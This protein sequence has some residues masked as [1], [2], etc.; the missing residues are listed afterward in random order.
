LIDPT[1]PDFDNK[2]GSS[3]RPTFNYELADGEFIPYVT[4]I[5]PFYN[6]GDIFLETAAS[7]FH[8]SFQQFEWI[9]IND[10]TDRPDSI[11]ILDQFRNKDERL[12]IVDHNN[13]KGLSAARNTGFKLAKAKYV[14]QIDSDDLLEETALEKWLWFLE[15][16]PEYSFCKG[17][18]IGF[19][20]EKYLWDYG[21][22]DG[23][24]F[25]AKNFTDA[26]C[27]VKKNVHTQVG[28]YDDKLKEGLEDWDFWIKCANSGF[29]GDNIPEYLNWY[30]RRKD[31]SDK[32][33]NLDSFSNNAN[34]I[35]LLKERYPELWKGKFPSI[36]D[37]ESSHE[38]KTINF[39]NY[40]N[41]LKKEK[42]RVLIL[43]SS[44][45]NNFEYDIS[46][47]F[48]KQ[49]TKENCELSVITFN[50]SNNTNL[51]KTCD[52][53]P[54]VFILPNFLRL[55]DYP[56]F[57]IYFLISRQ[58]DLILFFNYSTILSLIP[59][60][61]RLSSNIKLISLLYDKDI[62]Q[63]S[64]LNLINE[65]KQFIDLKLLL[66]LNSE[67]LK[68]HN[69]ISNNII[70]CK[71]MIDTE[72]WNPNEKLRSETR[73]GL[74]I[75]ED[76]RV[77]ICYF[78]DCTHKIRPR[79]LF[80][81]ILELAKKNLKFNIIIA[82]KGIN[83]DWINLL[84][85]KNNI[86]NYCR[87]V[88]IINDKILNRLFAASDLFFLP[89]EEVSNTLVI[90]RAM[91]FKLCIVGTSNNI[92]KGIID[93]K[94]G[95]VIEYSNE[96]D[97]I[98]EFTLILEEL[99]NNK[100]LINEIGDKCRNKVKKEFSVD[101]ISKEITNYINNS[102]N[103]IHSFTDYIDDMTID[104]IY[105]DLNDNHITLLK[106]VEEQKIT[107]MLLENELTHEIVV[108]KNSEINKLSHEI[109]NTTNYNKELIEGI[110]FW[111][112]NAEETAKKLNQLDSNIFVRLLLKLGLVKYK[113]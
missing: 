80:G 83:W 94:C 109:E 40:K 10:G 57:L 45:D 49:L 38:P 81:T 53:T 102:F 4:I 14:L 103:T 72:Y 24:S 84:L 86:E 98:R 106:N 67:N 75:S 64:A 105:S 88:K 110:E 13:N 108:K 8:Q 60:I 48:I 2:P 77:L 96:E 6:T 15:S 25:L 21:F 111:K 107:N 73:N 12:K 52:L 39:T 101:K 30:R 3:H 20:S 58:I 17:F 63:N 82:G 44:F 89:S 34:T 46:T 59:I 93:Q 56:T 1:D 51:S 55:C 37:F 87:R 68:K 42:R 90:L 91:S 99:I 41:N 18:S 16:Y 79:V 71:E 7:I 92:I 29:W 62:E 70:L 112:T 76:E 69:K 54:D 9:I 61:K 95:K 31:H 11:E 100:E 27:L 28:G 22:V 33:R 65:S 23:R 32:W 97:E 85:I 36:K 113:F 19:G 5:T 50:K 78:E 35:K 74:N 47:N 26:T 104:N 66:N 43:L